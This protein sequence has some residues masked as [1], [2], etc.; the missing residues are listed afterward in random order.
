MR[1]HDPKFSESNARPIGLGCPGFDKAFSGPMQRE[2]RLLLGG[3]D[4]HEPH[5]RTSDRFA[6][7]FRIAR[8]VLVGLH[9]G[10]HDLRG[11]EFDRMA[12]AL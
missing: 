6:D 4:R 5:G 7:R 8:I 1:R 10:A 9:V 3:L 2:K 11:H 12:Q